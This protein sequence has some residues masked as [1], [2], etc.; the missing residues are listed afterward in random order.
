MRIL[1]V[2]KFVYRRGGAEGYM[3]DVA[4]MQR[5]AGHDVELF[6]MDHPLNIEDLPLRDTFPPNVELE[7]AP[8]GLAGV[9]AGAR[10]V[11]SLSSSRGMARALERFQ[12]DVVHCHNIYHQLSSK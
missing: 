11:W 10:M 8:G 3:L 2:N 6:G 1:H 5:Q 9:S 4:A 7:P 12:P